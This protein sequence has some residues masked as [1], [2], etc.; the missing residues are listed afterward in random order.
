MR[1]NEPNK[2]LLSFFV[3]LLCLLGCQ[4]KQEKILM[5]ENELDASRL[6]IRAVLDGKFDEANLLMIQDTANNRYLA[7]VA[8]LYEKTT[9][10][11]KENYK[12]STIVIHSATATNDS[13]SIVI[14]SNSHKNDHD[15][16]RIVKRNSTWQVDLKYQYEHDYP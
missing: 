8:A 14:Y 5:P 2:R 11:E 1:L 6:F 4:P 7:Q 3:L 9:I 10:A 16:L 13:V 15:T 12:G